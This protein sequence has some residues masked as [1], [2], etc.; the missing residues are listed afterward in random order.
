MPAALGRAAALL[1]E[2]ELVAL[3]VQP[4]ADSVL[5][6]GLLGLALQRAQVPWHARFAPRATKEALAL[7]AEEAPGQPVVL[8]GHGGAGDADLDAWAGEAVVVDARWPRTP[9]RKAHAL[10]DALPGATAATLAHELAKGL[11][12]R[13]SPFLAL[14]GLEAAGP[15]EGADG[16]RARLLAE[17][18]PQGLALGPIPAL[19]GPLLEALAGCAS[20]YLPG[21]SGR[22]RAAKRF[23]D[24]LTLD[25]ARAAEDL[26]AAEAER[27]AS[28]LA[29]HL[30]AKGAPGPAA[31]LL[32]LPDARGPVPGGSARALAVRCAAACAAGKPG[33]ALALAL[34]DPRGEAEAAAQAEARQQRLLQA[35]LK[36]EGDGAGGPWRSE[37][38]LAAD[39]AWMGALA[40]RGGEPVAVLA[41]SDLHVAAPGHEPR[42][43]G[44]AAA[45][46]AQGVGGHGAALGHRALL[47]C[48]PGMAAPAWDRLRQRLGVVA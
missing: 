22:A 23:L 6:A 21:L 32:L 43:L 3:L 33:L 34:G 39:L 44:Q 18:K 15:T 7:L 19:Q 12:P 4:D 1:R 41:G 38:D 16:P 5:A 10:E 17:A 35:L 45:E 11:D 25:G 24:A 9:H 36:L 2:A 48:P 42:F 20:P 26:S 37:P 8:V 27:L 31:R 28:A 30:L 40:L 47:R 29:L 14:A 13:A 46:A